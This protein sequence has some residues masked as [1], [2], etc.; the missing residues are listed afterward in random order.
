MS[1]TINKQATRKS[2]FFGK[3][4]LRPAEVLDFPMK[5]HD[6]VKEE[7]KNVPSLTVIPDFK[8]AEDAY[9]RAEEHFNQAM[10]AVIAKLNIAE[11]QRSY[12][13]LQSE[14]LQAAR[15]NEV[16]Y[17]EF[18]VAQSKKGRA[19]ATLKAYNEAK[20]SKQS[21]EQRFQNQIQARRGELNE[22]ENRLKRYTFNMWGRYVGMWQNDVA[23]AKHQFEDKVREIADLERRLSEHQSRMVDAL[24]R[25]GEQAL[26]EGDV[27]EAEAILIQRRGI[28]QSKVKVLNE[29]ASALTEKF[30]EIREKC[31]HAGVMSLEAIE[32]I[33]VITASVKSDA[34]LLASIEQLTDYDPFRPIQTVGKVLL[35]T[36]QISE[37]L[38]EQ[39]DAL[40]EFSEHARDE[41]SFRPG[42]ESKLLNYLT[43]MDIEKFA[44]LQNGLL[45]MPRNSA[46]KDD[47]HLNIQLLK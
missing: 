31:K 27:A 10:A 42:V 21:I 45:S 12:E 29:K 6:L 4:G 13:R 18:V 43:I 30:E 1:K 24:N 40:D 19:D 26:A 22:I 41:L 39:S 38:Y 32:K 17:D 11:L 8:G 34:M 2:G 3:F 7:L 23:L 44:Q 46:E 33:S 16:A 47:M 28:Y 5:F 36:M 37:Y 35:L 9:A 25:G 20:A 15:E 14:N